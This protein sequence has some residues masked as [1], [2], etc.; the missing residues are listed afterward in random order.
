MTFL[1][2]CYSYRFLFTRGQE[3]DEFFDI[4][5]NAVAVESANTFVPGL[6]LS[7]AYPGASGTFK[8]GKFDSICFLALVFIVSKYLRKVEWRFPKTTED[9]CGSLATSEGKGQRHDNEEVIGINKGV[10]ST[11]CPLHTAR[12]RS[13]AVPAWLGLNAAAVSK[14]LGIVLSGYT[15]AFYVPIIRK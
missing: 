9:V 3:G 1:T 6:F 10:V 11:M 5:D 13:S 8:P 15:N 14:N 7:T 4:L 12:I 2:G